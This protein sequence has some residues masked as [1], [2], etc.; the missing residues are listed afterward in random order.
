M[1]EYV[2]AK[3]LTLK[4]GMRLSTPAP[5]AR[6]PVAY[7]H[8]ALTAK[9]MDENDSAHAL[10]FSIPLDEAIKAGIIEELY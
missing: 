10:H 5:L 2:L 9:G 6:A 3:D 7:A 1:A 4:A 8:G